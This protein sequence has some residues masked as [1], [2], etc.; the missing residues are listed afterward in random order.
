MRIIIFITFLILIFACESTKK[1][2]NLS[3]TPYGIIYHHEYRL[4]DK[5]ISSQ[6]IEKYPLNRRISHKDFEALFEQNLSSKEIEFNDDYLGTEIKF[7]ESEYYFIDYD[8]YVKSNNARYGI[9]EI[10]KLNCFLYHEKPQ[11]CISSEII[12]F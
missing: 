5:G 11:E 7:N 8:G 10:E 2:T 3:S 4:D 9:I 6:D 1:D 12:W